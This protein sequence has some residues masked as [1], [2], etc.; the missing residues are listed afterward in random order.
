M[1]FSSTEIIGYLASFIVLTSF[2]MKEIKTLRVINTIGCGM[3]V[4]YGILLH[5]SF[6]IILTNV[7][8]VGINMYFLIKANKNI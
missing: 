4:A 8:I 6:P 1:N 5:F 7:A 3:F 2:L